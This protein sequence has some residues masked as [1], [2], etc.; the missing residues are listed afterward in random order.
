MERYKIIRRIGYGGTGR[1]FLAYD[2]VERREVAIKAVH[3]ANEHTRWSYEAE[4]DA[5]SCIRHPRL[6][7]FLGVAEKDGVRYVVMEYIPGRSLHEIVASDG[8]QDIEFVRDCGMKLCEVIGYLHSLDPP[9]IYRDMKPANVILKPDGD[10]VLVDFGAARRQKP[11]SLED[12]VL[13]GTHG[14]AAPEQYGGY[15]QTDPRAD[16]YSLGATLFHIASGM[17]PRKYPLKLPMPPE[18]TE[19]QRRLDYIIRRST[20]RDQQERYRSCC[21]MSEDLKELFE[22]GYKLEIDITILQTSDTFN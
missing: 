17:P 18:P 8:A 7:V 1:V 14:Y 19:A 15:G 20:R 5:I 21:E 6:P 11:A 10:L 13:L 12:T 2:T 22:Y 4:V 3:T 16:V 9:V